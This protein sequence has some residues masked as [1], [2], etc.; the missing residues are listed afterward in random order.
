MR[1]SIGLAL[2]ALLLLSTAA[3]AADVTLKTVKYPELAKLVRAQ[4]GKVVIVDF[5]QFD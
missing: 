2:P 3:P 4:K 1:R 5:W